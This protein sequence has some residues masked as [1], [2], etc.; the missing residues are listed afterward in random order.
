MYPNVNIY[1]RYLP[2]LF[3]GT[4]NVAAWYRILP[5]LRYGSGRNGAYKL[6]LSRFHTTNIKYSIY[7]TSRSGSQSDLQVE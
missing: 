6:K 5:Y 7:L 1:P 2:N 4:P 3:D